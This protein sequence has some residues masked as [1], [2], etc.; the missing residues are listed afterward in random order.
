MWAVSSAVEHYVDIVV[1]TGSIPVPPTI[2]SPPPSGG[3]LFQGAR[4]PRMGEDHEGPELAPLAQ[5]ASSRL[6]G[7]A[8]QRPHLCDQQDAKTLQS[9]SGLRRETSVSGDKK[10]AS[11]NRAVFFFCVTKSCGRP[12]PTLSRTESTQARLRTTAR[13]RATVFGQFPPSTASASRR[14]TVPSF[15]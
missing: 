10:T 2:Y 9:P 11:G 15:R 8:P 1:A 4:A 7:R 5:A 6:P 14:T 13:R 3:P 12:P